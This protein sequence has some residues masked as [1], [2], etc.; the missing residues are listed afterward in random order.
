[1]TETPGAQPKPEPDQ[2][3]PPPGGYQTP[4][5]P[6]GYQA[7]PPSGDQAPPAGYQAP[8]AGYQAPPPG[9]QAPPPG[10]Q[11]PPAGYQAPPPGY[12]PP[13]NQVNVGD[14]FGWGWAKFQQ[15]V[16]AFLL[17]IVIYGVAAAII[18]GIPYS[19]MIA[20][21]SRITIDA[22]G[23]LTSGGGMLGLGFGALAVMMI[24]SILVGFLEAAGLI[25]GALR[26]AN[27]ERVTL[28]DFF[29]YPNLASVIGTAVLVGLAAGIAGAITFGLGGMVVAFFGAFA[30]F[31]AVDQGMGAIDA[32][33]ASFQLASK[34]FGP[35][36]LVVLVAV[37]ANFVGGLIVIG[38]LVTVPLSLLALTFTYRRLV[39]GPV[40]A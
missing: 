9:Y 20:G 34:N 21:A 40:A 3:P 17:A 24:L 1:M 19:I 28:G 8:P 16:A 31:F 22:N 7:P 33:K 26:V 6:G 39:N 35:V 5:P 4:P 38:T 32:I 12:G 15:N 25:N 18:I 13:P 14:A 10:Y 23:N 27:G 30:L 29:K 36:I 37:V 2:T 11:A